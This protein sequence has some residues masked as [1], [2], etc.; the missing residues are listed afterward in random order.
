MSYATPEQ[1]SQAFG[2]REATMLSDRSDLGLPDPAVIQEAL[3]RAAA[4]VD[5]ALSQHHALPLPAP[6]VQQLHMLRQM[7]LDIARYRLTGA[8]GVSVTSSTETR[9]K[10]AREMLDKIMAGK[11]LMS[12]TAATDG[13]AAG[14][15]PT[16]LTAGEAEFDARDRVLAPGLLRDYLGG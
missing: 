13:T 11:V 6:T 12:G 5:F 15:S 9:Y 4:E 7:E 8:S 16:S 14:L 10:E 1:F 3:D 2:V